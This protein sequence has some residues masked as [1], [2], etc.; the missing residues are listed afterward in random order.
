MRGQ[1]L[2]KSSL[3]MWPRSSLLL[4]SRCLSPVWAL[5]SWVRDRGGPGGNPPCVCEGGRRG[6]PCV[7]ELGRRRG[8]Y[9]GEGGRR[10]GTGQGETGGCCRG[11]AP[12]K[13]NMNY[14]T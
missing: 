14:F 11:S 5:V 3:L 9:V 1:M 7:G 6:G 2:P 13:E 10:E 12:D 4:W 8:P